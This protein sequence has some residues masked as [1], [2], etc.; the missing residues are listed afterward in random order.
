MPFVQVSRRMA[1]ARAGRRRTRQQF[2][3]ES[4][5][6]GLQQAQSAARN[7][8]EREQAQIQQQYQTQ[9]QSY[10]QQMG[11][12]EQAVKS[13]QERSQEYNKAVDLYNTV[14][15]Y[16]NVRFV[17]LPRADRPATYLSAEPGRSEAEWNR[18]LMNTPSGQALSGLPGVD[19]RVWAF[20][21]QARI[22]GFDASKLPADFVLKEVDRSPAGYPIFS[23]SKRAGSDPGEFTEPVPQANIQAPDAPSFEGLSARYE[24]SIREQGVVAE[25]EIGER[26]AA[27]MRARR[28]M[29][30]RPLLSEG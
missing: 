14:V 4:L 13:F 29:T 6:G 16:D 11:Q 24:Q 28:R 25:R 30:D 23:L 9:L 19:T 26:R 7:E 15:P 8:F 5:T 10:T 27:S 3:I 18:Y 21:K 22:S 20:D 2:E 1:E 12:F 17:A